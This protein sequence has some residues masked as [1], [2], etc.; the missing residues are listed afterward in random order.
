[1]KA[2]ILVFCFQESVSAPV[3]PAPVSPAPAAAGGES[4]GESHVL[5][6]DG[7]IGVE[8]TPAP[9]AAAGGVTVE[10]APQD[11]PK[12]STPIPASPEI[13]LVG[14]VSETEI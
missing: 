12:I 11:V 9:T 5:S 3:S 10:D 14:H 13:G 6:G 4:G 8:I 1:M 2:S 7:V